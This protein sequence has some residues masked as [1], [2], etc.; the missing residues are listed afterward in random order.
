MTGRVV[1]CPIDEMNRPRG[2]QQARL[3]IPPAAGQVGRLFAGWRQELV[4]CRKFAPAAR[5]HTACRLMSEVGLRVNEACQPGV[6]RP[7]HP[8]RPAAFC[9]RASSIL[10][11]L[12]RGQRRRPAKP[13]AHLGDLP[14][15]PAG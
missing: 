15:P 14:G 7:G 3:R 12:R 4:R 11:T 9:A 13:V 6:A 10:W 1:G 8:P 2:R 5:N